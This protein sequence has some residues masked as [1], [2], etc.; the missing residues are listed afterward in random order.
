MFAVC[1]VFSL[2]NSGFSA[3]KG[4]EENELFKRVGLFAKSAVLKASLAEIQLNIATSI[5]F[6]REGDLDLTHLQL[7]VL[8]IFPLLRV[9][10]W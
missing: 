2:T 6:R 5:E 7:F 8:S 10:I 9:K 3:T 4:K 1:L